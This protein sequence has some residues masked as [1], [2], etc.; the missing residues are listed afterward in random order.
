[1]KRK[2]H[3]VTAM[4][5]LLCVSWCSV[6]VHAWAMETGMA[7]PR[8]PNVQ[9]M[10]IVTQSADS[11]V[12]ADTWQDTVRKNTRIDIRNYTLAGETVEAVHAYRSVVLYEDEKSFQV[13][14]SSGKGAEIGRDIRDPFTILNNKNPLPEAVVRWFGGARWEP[15]GTVAFNGKQVVRQRYARTAADGHPLVNVAYLDPD[16]GLPIK[17]EQYISVVL[18]QTDGR[19]QVTEAAPTWVS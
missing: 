7:A 11:I 5:A 18:E 3:L 9:H 15:A 1:M 16:T 2:K 14:S 13:T 6:A 17:E 8:Q 12:I 19:W 4:T 10:Q